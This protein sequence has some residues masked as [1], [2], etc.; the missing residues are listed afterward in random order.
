MNENEILTTQEEQPG[1]QPYI[2]AI[3]ELKSTTVS[4]DLYNKIVAERDQ[5][6]KTVMTNPPTTAPAEVEQVRSLKECNRALFS[7]R[8]KNACD[9]M[10]K[11]LDVRD[12]ALREG[13]PD[14]FLSISR[15]V[16]PGAMSAR[17]AEEI[18]QIYRDCLDYADGDPRIFEQEISRRML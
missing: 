9:L 5:L 13:E 17:R 8:P 14:P 16:T 2:D 1:F 15:H 3:Q 4:K 10:S 18:A 6:I 12:A 11:M 7:E